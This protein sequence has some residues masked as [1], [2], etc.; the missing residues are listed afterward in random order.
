MKCKKIP[1]TITS[2]IFRNKFK[3][4][5]QNFKNYTTLLKEIEDLNKCKDKPC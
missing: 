1:S 5:I 4:K 2:K 3:R